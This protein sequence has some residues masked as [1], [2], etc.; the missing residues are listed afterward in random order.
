MAN[1]N[2]AISFYPIG[3]WNLSDLREFVEGI[4]AIY[5]FFFILNHFENHYGV[6]SLLSKYSYDSTLQGARDSVKFLTDLDDYTTSFEKLEI[7]K[8]EMGSPDIF[9]LSGG[10]YPTTEET[11]RYL[12][13]EVDVQLT[14]RI[15]AMKLDQRTK[16]LMRDGLDRARSKIA[17]LAFTHKMNMG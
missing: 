17:I 1:D 5:N 16:D 3:R 4:T 2:Y 8:I 12:R 9:S 13:Q 6:E 15:N 11:N 7:Q 10:D 14:Q